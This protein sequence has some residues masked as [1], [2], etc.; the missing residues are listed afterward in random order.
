VKQN[1]VFRAYRYGIEY[2]DE[3]LQTTLQNMEP[4]S[5]IEGYRA[6]FDTVGLVNP[7]VFDWYLNN[8]VDGTTNDMYEFN[9]PGGSGDWAPIA[10]DWD[11]D[12]H[13]TAG[14]YDRATQTFHLIN[15]SENITD[16][17]TVFAAPAA[18]GNWLPIAGDWN[19]DGLST[20]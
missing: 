20:T 8:R 17:A 4:G 10:G 3:P 13:D 9:W 16:P 19:G 11:G 18:Q 1:L 7:T 15:Q 12:G 14:I 6:S 2:F 5:P